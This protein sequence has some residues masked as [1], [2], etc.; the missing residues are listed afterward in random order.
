MAV[1]IYIS[2]NSVQVFP[3]LCILANICYL[4]V[5]CFITGLLSEGVEHRANND[6]VE[7]LISLAEMTMS[8]LRAFLH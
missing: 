5:A 2:P 8:P 1:P 6:H 3:F 7:Y 4:F